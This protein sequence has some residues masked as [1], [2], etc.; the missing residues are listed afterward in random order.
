MLMERETFLELKKKGE[1]SFHRSELLL[2]AKKIQHLSNLIYGMQ[3]VVDQMNHLISPEN[4]SR[5]I[6]NLFSAQARELTVSPIV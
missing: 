3:W 4:S 6:S 2:D 1:R 5:N